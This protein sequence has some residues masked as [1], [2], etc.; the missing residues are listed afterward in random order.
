MTIE[1]TID[2]FLADLKKSRDTGPNYPWRE[3]CDSA[4]SETEPSRQRKS[5][6]VAE[7]VLYGR[8]EQLRGRID[9]PEL[10]DE[11][12]ALHLA[13]ERLRSVS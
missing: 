10:R 7:T 11:S 1:E 8:R 13:I 12:E 4:L 6:A 9:D 3:A 2:R 5:I